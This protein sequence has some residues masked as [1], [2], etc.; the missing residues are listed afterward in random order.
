MRA[1][2]ADR[3]QDRRSGDTGR[4]GSPAN[5]DPQGRRRP[6]SDLVSAPDAPAIT[7]GGRR[8]YRPR[9]NTRL[10][11]GDSM[12]ESGRSAR[13]YARSTRVTAIAATL[14]TR[15][16]GAGRPSGVEEVK[17][18]L[19][20]PDETPSEHADRASGPARTLP[21]P[22]RPRPD[23]GPWP[24]LPLD[25]RRCCRFVMAIVLT[26]G[27]ARHSV[28]LPGFWCHLA[29]QEV[30]KPWNLRRGL[31]IGPAL[32]SCTG[33]AGRPWWPVPCGRLARGRAGMGVRAGCGTRVFRRAVAVYLLFPTTLPSAWLSQG[34][35]LCRCPGPATR[36]GR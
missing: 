2:A 13:R 16:A 17:R 22:G 24:A 26:S 7:G 30:R 10:I 31:P 15:R 8:P 19:D 23:D 12:A 9:A 32:P 11:V 27:E 18:H 29:G 28:H 33:V 4:H 20:D 1:G 14:C 25:V 21:R 34:T 6:R 5:H 3:Q 35:V 36:C